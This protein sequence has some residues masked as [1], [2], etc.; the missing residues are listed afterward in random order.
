MDSLL[1][2]NLP[3]PMASPSGEAG[4]GHRHCR[5]GHHHVL[6]EPGGY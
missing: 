3:Q 4:G 5:N 6:A 2:V 1:A